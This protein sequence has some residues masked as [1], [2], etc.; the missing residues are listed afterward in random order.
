L[1]RIY[2]WGHVAVSNRQVVASWIHAW[3]YHMHHTT[4]WPPTCDYEH[5][6]NAHHIPSSAPLPYHTRLA[7]QCVGERQYSHLHRTPCAAR[8]CAPPHGPK[9]VGLQSPWKPPVGLSGPGVPL[10]G[11]EFKRARC[12]VFRS[13]VVLRDAHL[14]SRGLKHLAGP[15]TA[16]PRRLFRIYMPCIKSDAP[17]AQSWMAAQRGLPPGV[18]SDASWVLSWMTAH[19]RARHVW[20]NSYS[21]FSI[22]KPRA[23]QAR[24]QPQARPYYTQQRCT[25]SSQAPCWGGDSRSSSSTGRC[26]AGSQG[27]GAGGWRGC[28][29]PPWSEN[30][31]TGTP[32]GRGE[33]HCPLTTG[34]RGVDVTFVNGHRRLYRTHPGQTG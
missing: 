10:I 9:T 19:I 11:A 26:R 12:Y 15:K 20:R 17:W 34:Y 13:E 24:P 7:L 30:V 3:R 31:L 23:A 16:S 8:R 32:G 28:G 18:Q 2:A 14:V 5:A 1:V 6:T 29:V 33:R 27:A 22:T 4:L 25:C 21:V